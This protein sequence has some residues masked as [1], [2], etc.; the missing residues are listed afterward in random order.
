MGRRRCGRKSISQVNLWH[1]VTTTSRPAS[2]AC[3]AA[4]ICLNINPTSPFKRNGRESE[5][6]QVDSGKLPAGCTTR[7]TR[8]CESPLSNYDAA[9]WRVGKGAKNEIRLAQTTKPESWLPNIFTSWCPACVLGGILWP[10]TYRHRDKESVLVGYSD[11]IPG[12]WLGVCGGE[13]ETQ[14][15]WKKG[16]VGKGPVWPFVTTIGC[17]RSLAI[18]GGTVDNATGLVGDAQESLSDVPFCTVSNCERPS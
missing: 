5:S 18:G 13:S 12:E 4:C 1:D 7:S 11:M 8:P 10:I 15:K 14:Q 3:F 2:Y 6:N 16:E 17:L 9:S